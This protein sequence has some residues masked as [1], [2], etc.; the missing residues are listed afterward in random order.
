MMR[1]MI[2]AD[3]TSDAF[4]TNTANNSA[5]EQTVVNDTTTTIDNADI[6]LVSLF[7]NPDPVTEGNSVTIGF[8]V[9]NIGSQSAG[10]FHLQIKRDG[11]TICTWTVFGLGANR[12]FERGP[13]LG[14]ATCSGTYGIPSAQAPG[15]EIS[16]IVDDLNQGAE[17][18][19][20]NNTMIKYMAV[21]R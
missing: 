6:T 5:T 20:G 13:G 7:D 14:G 11:A 18:N 15:Y 9:K 12:V 3:I 17:S 1:E 2:T 19:E 16:F 21:G 10:P 4:D 8:R